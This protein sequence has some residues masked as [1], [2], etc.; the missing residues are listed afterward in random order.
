MSDASVLRPAQL[1]TQ[2]VRARPAVASVTASGSR[3]FGRGCNQVRRKR[4]RVALF[5]IHCSVSFL[6]CHLVGGGQLL[7]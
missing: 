7:A 3:L 4:T 6:L 2:L 1:K 5:P